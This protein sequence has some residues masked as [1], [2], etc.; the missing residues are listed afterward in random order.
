M[1][2][3]RSVDS[4]YDDPLLQ[5]NDFD[6]ST[7]ATSQEEIYDLLCMS[8]SGSRGLI[9]VRTKNE[10]DRIE[11]YC[12]PPV[13]NHTNYSKGYSI[14]NDPIQFYQPVHDVTL[15]R[16]DDKSVDLLFNG[17]VLWVNL[18]LRRIL[19]EPTIYRF[20]IHKYSTLSKFLD[21]KYVLL[22]DTSCP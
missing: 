16:V 13:K 18:Q 17:K 4:L 3:L 12:P 22:T 19:A 11:I 5:V 2:Y 9:V 10:H 6:L 15:N 7:I 8:S 21:G 1:N 14:C 20:P